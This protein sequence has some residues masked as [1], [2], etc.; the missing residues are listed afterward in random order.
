MRSSFASQRLLAIVLL[1]GAFALLTACA[2]F[3]HTYRANRHHKA[4]GA[5]AGHGPPPH[6]PAHGY[7]HKLHHHGGL[8]IAFD[9]GLGVYAV[10]NHPDLFFWEDQFYRLSDRAWHVS[11]YLDHGWVSIGTSRLPRHLAKKHHPAK[12]GHR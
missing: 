4:G 6:A 3:D 9:S 11:A 2:H 1:A 10:V 7:R 12:R 5:H 8:Q